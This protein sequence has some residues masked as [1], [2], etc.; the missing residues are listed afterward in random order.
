M[1]DRNLVEVIAVPVDVFDGLVD[2]LVIAR[3]LINKE[4]NIDTERY[5][6]QLVNTVSHIDRCLE[7][8]KLEA[9][10]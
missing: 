2:L 8:D 4:T 9:A 10:S 5:I 3:G 1:D 6:K 7:G